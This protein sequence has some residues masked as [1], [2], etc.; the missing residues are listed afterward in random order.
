MQKINI[1]NIPFDL[2]YEGYYWYSNSKQPN[3]VENTLISSAIFTEMPF[4][5]EGNFF[6][7]EKQIS[8]SIKNIDGTYLITITDFNTLKISNLVEQ[9]YIAKNE[10]TGIS[11][12][13]LAQYWEE[14]EADP[15]LENMKTLIPTWV[16]FK[17]FIK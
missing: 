16:A 5:V 12:I 2:E 7:E 13:K 11:K 17:G 1:N 14:G 3:I 10:L 8:I 6:N 4:I 15:Y 9:N